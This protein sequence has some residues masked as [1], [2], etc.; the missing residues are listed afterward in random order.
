MD[1]RKGAGKLLCPDGS[2]YEGQ[3]DDDKLNNLGVHIDR[4]GNHYEGFFKM[5]LKSGVGRLAF[6]DGKI[7]EG[8]FDNVG[9]KG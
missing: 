1:K 2:F 9:S 8:H 4:W 7:Y 3:F 5:G 6:S